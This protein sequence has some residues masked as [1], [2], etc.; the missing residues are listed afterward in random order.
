MGMVDHIPD[1]DEWLQQGINLVNYALKQGAQ[2]EES[3]VCG[4]V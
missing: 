1:V 2:E 3:G 4:G